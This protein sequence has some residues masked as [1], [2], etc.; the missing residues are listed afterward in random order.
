[1]RIAYLVSAYRLLAEASN[2]G[3]RGNS[4]DARTLEQALEDIQLL[5]SKAQAEKARELATVMASEG[6]AS[7][8]NLLKTLRDD[9]R[10]ELGLPALVDPP[11]HLRIE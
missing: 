10:E 1:M 5:G 11:I 9:L 7:T 4:R 2:R 6:G 3:L 8:D